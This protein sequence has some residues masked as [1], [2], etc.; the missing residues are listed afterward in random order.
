MRARV[1]LRI[2]RSAMTAR[3]EVGAVETDT[4]ETVRQRHHN[5]TQIPV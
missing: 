1:S 4:C 3:N 5:H 2:P